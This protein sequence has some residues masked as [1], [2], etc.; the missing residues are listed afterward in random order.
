MQG[1]RAQAQAMHP[2]S[3]DLGKRITTLSGVTP[4]LV[5]RYRGVGHLLTALAINATIAS[6]FYATLAVSSIWTFLSNIALGLQ[7][8]G[9]VACGV[10]IRVVVVPANHKNATQVARHM[11]HF[12]PCPTNH[13]SK[14]AVEKFR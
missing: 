3:P 8:S 10:L 14:L 5:L 4:H 2:R 13:I 1:S 11:E 9:V 6:Y 7:D 12:R